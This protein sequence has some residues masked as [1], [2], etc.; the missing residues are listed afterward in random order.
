MLTPN[1]PF[2]GSPI[3]NGFPKVAPELKFRLTLS[4]GKLTINPL[5]S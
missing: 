4:I 1:I 5:V 2:I 3:V